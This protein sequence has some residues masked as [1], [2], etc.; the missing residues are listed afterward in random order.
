MHIQIYAY[1]NHSPKIVWNCF[2]L[3]SSTMPDHAVTTSTSSQIQEKGS[4]SL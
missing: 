3:N 4:Q 2:M 1:V